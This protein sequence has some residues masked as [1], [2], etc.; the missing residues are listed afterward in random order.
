MIPRT[1]RPPLQSGPEALFLKETFNGLKETMKKMFEG[2][3]IESLLS[4]NWKAGKRK[5]EK[6]DK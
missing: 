6:R 1:V 3:L 4:G 5:W 2:I